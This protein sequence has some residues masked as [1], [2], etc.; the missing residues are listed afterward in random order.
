MTKVSDYRPTP[1]LLE[2]WNEV[3]VVPAVAIGGITPENC[4]PLVQAGADFIAVVTGV[5][6]HPEG[7]AAAVRAYNHAIAAA[8]DLR[9]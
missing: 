6:N 1:D 8:L 4:V 7:P 3:M 9:D 2:W 5:W